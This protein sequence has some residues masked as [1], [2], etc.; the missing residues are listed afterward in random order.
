MTI[1]TNGA[2]AGVTFLVYIAA[3]I[4]TLAAAGHAHVVGVLTIV[5]SFAALVL[6]VTLYAVTRDIDPDLALLAMLCRVV[7]SV[8]GHKGGP[9]FFAVGS[10]LFCWLLCRG[11]LIPVALAGL[12]V[13][14][15]AVLV[16]LLLLQRAG[17][18]SAAS[19]WSSSITWLVWL[20]MLVFELA[21][22]GWLI[23]KG[24]AAP[25]RRCTV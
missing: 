21:F 12:G 15:S 22:A 9:I 18:F 1:R 7:E 23:V 6:G 13:T 25:E 24:V 5:T 3:G 8:P 11:R 19:T 14:T 20:P 4:G 2:V 16:G 17:L 10:T